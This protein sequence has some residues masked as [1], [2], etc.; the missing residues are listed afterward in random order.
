MIFWGSR[1]K[2]ECACVGEVEAGTK[3]SMRRS[4]GSCEHGD[5]DDDVETGGDEMTWALDCLGWSHEFQD[6]SSLI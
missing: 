5:E 3:R 6:F 1:S 4:D 2:N